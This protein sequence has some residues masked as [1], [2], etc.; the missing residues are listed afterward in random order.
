M[1]LPTDTPTPGPTFTPTIVPTPFIVVDS[2]LVSLRTGPGVEFP[3]YA[4]LGPGIPI[5]IIGQHPDGRWYQICCISGETVWVAA[6]HVTAVNPLNTVPQI[7]AG[8]PPTPTPT[9]TPTETGTPTPT[10][11]ATPYPFERAIGPQFFPT[12]NDFLTIWVKMFVG[13]PPDEEPAADHYITVLFDGVERFNSLGLQPSK[14]VFEE[15]GS[16]GAGNRVEYNLKYEY[17]PPD[18][19]TEDPNSDLTRLQLLGTG[20]WTVFVFRRVGQ[21]LIG[22]SHLYDNT[23]QPQP[24]GL[25]RLG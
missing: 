22:R 25:P 13:T 7:G 11:T 20:T 17:R 9:F 8:P 16:P 4:Q 5:A 23:K 12:N 24:R 2:G 19:K 21:S 6:Q 18:P 1:V 3:L 15:S 10:P 14:G